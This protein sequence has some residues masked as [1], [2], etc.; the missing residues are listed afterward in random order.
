[1]GVEQKR[2][3]CRRLRLLI[4][5]TLSKF[6]YAHTMHTSINEYTVCI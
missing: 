1:M 2:R 4:L 5:H 3:R 6:Y